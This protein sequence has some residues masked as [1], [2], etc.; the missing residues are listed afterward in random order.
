MV[1]PVYLIWNLDLRLGLDL[2]GFIGFLFEYR[3]D[4][5]HKHRWVRAGSIF[6]QENTTLHVG[7][8]DLLQASTGSCAS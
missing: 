4:E 2:V 6:T 8:S 7:I 5:T 3:C 1:Q